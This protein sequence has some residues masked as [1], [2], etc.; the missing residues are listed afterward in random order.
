M[1]RHLENKEQFNELIKDKV[2]VDFYAEWCGPCKMLA[3]NLEKLDYNILKVDV[4]KFQDLAISYGVMSVPTLILFKNG[5][6]VN[7]S[8]GYLDIDELKEM[9]GH[10]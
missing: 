3:P 7:K 9:V 5:K 8:I 1:I 4:D 6:E 2:L 10:E